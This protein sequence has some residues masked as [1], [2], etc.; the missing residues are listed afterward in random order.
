[1]NIQEPYVFGSDWNKVDK[2]LHKDEGLLCAALSTTSLSAENHRAVDAGRKQTCKKCQTKSIYS[3][4]CM[5]ARITQHYC[6]Y[7]LNSRRC[8]SKWGERKINIVGRSVA[9]WEHYLADQV[10]GET[11][12]LFSLHYR[13]V[14][15]DYIHLQ[16][17]LNACFIFLL[18]CCCCCKQMTRWGDE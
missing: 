11:S 5:L 3:V 12:A 13:L 18:F 2:G 17:V 4:A 9:T 1:M 15:Y 10:I 8:E 16:Q 14:V 7:C 6:L